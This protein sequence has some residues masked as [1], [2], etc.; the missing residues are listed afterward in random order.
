MAAEIIEQAFQKCQK[1]VQ[2]DSRSVA[3]GNKTAEDMQAG[4]TNLVPASNNK[5]DE[6]ND[7]GQWHE[8]TPGEPIAV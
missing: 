4:M 2:R 5:F 7:N 6:R 8:G 3:R 1:D